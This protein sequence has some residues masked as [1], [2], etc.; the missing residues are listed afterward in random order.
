MFSH[1]L[2]KQ[3]DGLHSDLSMMNDLD[4][5]GMCDDDR[6]ALEM[7]CDDAES[8][9]SILQAELGAIRETDRVRVECHMEEKDG[10]L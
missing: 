6:K 3:L 4:P 10:P 5:E 8:V 2:L 1:L 7:L 9:C